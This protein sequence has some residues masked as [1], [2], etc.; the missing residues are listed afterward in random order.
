MKLNYI[1]TLAVIGL[2]TLAT[3]FYKNQ[4]FIINAFKTSVYLQTPEHMISV[5]Q[6]GAP[7]KST[8]HPETVVPKATWKSIGKERQLLG[9]MMYSEDLK[10]R[11]NKLI[12]RKATALDKELLMFLGEVID[13][14]SAKDS[15]KMSR[16]L[17]ITPQAKEIDLI[18]KKK[19]NGFFI[20]AGGYDG[21]RS[22]NSIF[23][24]KERGWTGL[25]VEPDPY[26]YTQLM[27]KNRHSWSINGCIS[28]YD[29]VSEI[30]FK[31]SLGGSG[32][33]EFGPTNAK[34]SVA[35]Y[36][37]LSMLTAL[38]VSSVDYFS[39]DVEGVEGVILES[40]PYDKLNISTLSVEYRHGD[41]RKYKETMAEHGYKMTKDLVL[42]Q[43]AVALWVDD[44]IFVKKSLT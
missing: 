22:S 4:T 7:F 43:P 12:Q 6:T 5:G 33:L 38:G 30:A 25:L 29:Y 41:K 36:P 44:F 34:F 14:P 17:A 40:L 15:I 24:E 11:L 10:D 27:G 23:F 21:E 39:L 20:E 13:R 35:C 19:T 8:I 1:T 37:L 3:I 18:L 2:I 26:F 31:Q 28:P 9:F 32:K 16:P 42:H